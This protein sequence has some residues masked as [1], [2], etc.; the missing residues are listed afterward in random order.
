MEINSTVT[1]IQATDP[2][3]ESVQ[4]SILSGNDLRQFAVDSESGIISVIR[5]LDRETLTK[6]QLVI[7]A[8]DAGGLSNT[9]ITNIK[10]T[11]FNDNSPEFDESTLPYLFSVDEGKINA[12]VG[13]VQAYDMDE[14]INSEIVYSV[15]PN[16]PF[17]I[18]SETGEIRTKEKLSFKKQNEYEFMVAATDRG[19]APL[20]ST[21]RIKISVK[22]VP[23]VAPVFGKTLMEVKVPENVP[24]YL[25]ATV[26]ASNH[27]IVSPITYTIKRNASR[28]LFAIN[29]KTGEIRTRSGLDYEAKTTHEIV[30]G[31]VEN[32]GKNPGDFIKIKVL[33]EDRNDVAPGFLITPEPISLTDDQLIGTLIASMPAVDTDGTS[34]GNVVR[35]EMIGK[36]K[37]LKYFH[38]DPENGNIKIKDDLRK[39]PATQYD[40]DVRAYDLGEPQLSSVSSL[41][42][43]VKH[44]PKS[45]DDNSTPEIQVD[46]EEFGL[47]FGDEMY[48]TNI[49][50]STSINATIKLIQVLNTR[51]VSKNKSGLSCQIV[52]GNDLGI[53]DVSLE[54]SACAIKLRKYLDFE[55][56][57]THELTIKL[58]SNKHLVNPQRSQAVLKILVQDYNDN[59]PVFKFKEINKS[60]QRNDTYYGVVNYNATI[61][62]NVLK[63]EAYDDDSGIFGL[64]K[65]R[66]I[67]DDSNSISKYDMASTFF[68][69]TD[70]GLLKT[71]R[72]FHKIQEGTF[73]FYVEARDNYGK[74]TGTVH[75]TKAR[76]VINVI[77]DVNRMTLVFSDSLPQDVR[78]HARALEEML[79]E[80]SN[81]LVTTI[82]KFS[83]RRSLTQNGSIVDI[84]T[85]TD[86]WFY[87]INPRTEKILERNSTEI[88]TRLLE[89]SIQSQINIAASRLIRATADGIFGP[90]EAENEIQHLE[91]SNS[92]EDNVLHYSLISV[93]VVIS[94]IGITGIIYVCVWWNK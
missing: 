23:D 12:Q 34:P 71:R 50:E 40:I 93:A 90:V 22:D 18:H 62:T 32:N 73:K 15:P 65:Y 45:H 47:A 83:N 61:G 35:Y 30:V 57:T 37:A 21:I 4:Y 38:I 26:K 49:P 28:E 75:S 87:A 67:D 5:K 41:M 91:V 11:D 51:K 29:P 59:S 70:T 86:V 24:D 36:G 46:S 72:P 44:I 3:F 14:G 58:S 7:Q 56:R 63:V 25:V 53:F 88:F 79:S 31:T 69:I 94:L 33:V 92:A 64:I 20:S 60:F 74:D 77:S 27:D 82:E 16:V 48:V 2:E 19:S 42:I 80:K 76:V 81:G 9:A 10:V 52:S 13:F 17:T 55:N 8:E 78:R 66:L 54:E 89:P 84:P 85:A 1:T 43:F 68:T 39:E 6:Y